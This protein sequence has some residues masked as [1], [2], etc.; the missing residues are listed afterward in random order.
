MK[1]FLIGLPGS[2]K[3]TIG[4]ALAERLAIPFVDLD[5]EVENKEGCSV[6]QIFEKKGEPYFR[7][8]EASVL[9]EISTRY[10]SFVMATG[11]GTPCFYDGIE[12]MN[13]MGITVFLN[14]PVDTLSHR[15]NKDGVTQRPLLQSADNIHETLQQLKHT[16]LKFYE[17][18]THHVTDPDAN[19]LIQ[20][21]R[22]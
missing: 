5:A 18:A 8:A 4:R 2:G 12:F 20:L 21:L 11:G 3:T 13:S 1:I 7:Q 10:D 15:L 19:K 14:V 22:T 6:A 9:R 16:R 17:Q